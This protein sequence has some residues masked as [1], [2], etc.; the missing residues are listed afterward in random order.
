M[1][2]II[3]KCNH[4][5]AVAMDIESI[6]VMKCLCFVVGCPVTFNWSHAIRVVPV[7]A[8]CL[9]LSL[10]FSHMSIKMLLLPGPSSPKRVIVQN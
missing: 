7:T 6:P 8:T 9:P 3:I 10:S 1:P 2:I 5:S 4:C